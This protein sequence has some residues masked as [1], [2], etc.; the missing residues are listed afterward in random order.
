MYLGSNRCCNVP[1]Q[2]SIIG[3]QG[4]QG[5]AGPIGPMGIT[6]SLGALGITGA[7]GICYRGYKGPQGAIGPTGGI[8]G[9]T[10]A[11]GP[12]GPTGPTPNNQKYKQF[13][14]TISNG[15]SY[16]TDT[17]LNTNSS[18][19]LDNTIT[20]QSGTYAISWTVNETWVDPNNQ[21]FISFTE[22]D[23]ES[24]HVP[25]LYKS[26]NP[27][28]LYANNNKSYGIGNDVINFSGSHTYT[29]NLIQSNSKGNTIGISGQT[30]NFS[31]TFIPLS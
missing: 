3:P 29:I 5:Q 20:L 17:Y 6:G 10:G 14:F 25:N 12:V 9:A 4:A 27:Y 21:F 7:T 23:D 24:I 1:V 13:S 26:A 11:P 28:V 16:T 30:V 15:V 8:R 19:S 2:K 18:S 31:I 22:Q